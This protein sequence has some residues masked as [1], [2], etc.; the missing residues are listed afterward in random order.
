MACSEVEAVTSVCTP[1]RARTTWQTVG[2]VPL[3]EISQPELLWLAR[4]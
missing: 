2:F 3:A 4:A 1:A